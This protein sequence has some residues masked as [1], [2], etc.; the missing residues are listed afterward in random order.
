VAP[1]FDLE[2]LL[3][4]CLKDDRSRVARDNLDLVAYWAPTDKSCRPKCRRFNND[5]D[6]GKNWED[7]RACLLADLAQASLGP[8]QIPYRRGIDG[9]IDKKIREVALQ[10]R[11]QP[12]R[13]AK[14]YGAFVLKRCAPDTLVEFHTGGNRSQRRRRSLLREG[15]TRQ[16]NRRSRTPA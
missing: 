9:S 5:R 7:I 15:R 2:R 3:R 12:V 6:L 10:R 11:W 14:L 8:G 4:T 13:K 1:V 16:S